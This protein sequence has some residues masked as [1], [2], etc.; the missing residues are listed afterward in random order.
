[1]AIHGGS[2]ERGTA[3]IATARPPTAAG[4]SLYTVVQPDDFRWHLPSHLVGPEGSPALAELPRPRRPRRVD[5]RLRAR[6]VLD[7]AAAR[8]ARP[9][10]R[11]ARSAPVLRAGL[12]GYEIVDDLDAIPSPLRGLHP[13]NPVNRAAVRGRPARAPAARAR[14]RA[15]TGDPSTPTGWWPRSPRRRR[16]RG[17]RAP[18]VH[19]GPP[20]LPRRRVDDGPAPARRARAVPPGPRDERRRGRG[21]RSRPRLDPAAHGARRAPAAGDL[22][23]RRA[24]DVVLRRRWSLGRALD[25]DRRHP[26]ARGRDLR[27]RARGV[28]LRRPRDRARRC[29]LA[30]VVLRRCTARRSASTRSARGCSTPHRRR[31]RSA[32]RGRCA[33]RTSTSSA[34]ST[35]RS[36]GPRSRTSSPAGST[37][38]G[39]VTARSSSGPGSTRATSPS[40]LVD[41]GDGRRSRC[42]SW[43]ATRS[44]PR[45]GRPPAEPRAG[46]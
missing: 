3:E 8:R 43:S 36:T 42:G 17:E 9:G 46:P 25:V 11:G 23:G 12:D 6:R 37:A 21:P 13:E 1:M 20:G 27:G 22:R 38:A 7:P 10:A 28:G 34:T 45:S 40:S 26:C 33:S 4:A 5:P 41:A 39:S 16:D 19:V 35:T 29:S 44:G 31:T 15:R 18:A 30:A 14:A 32:G 2:L 24:H